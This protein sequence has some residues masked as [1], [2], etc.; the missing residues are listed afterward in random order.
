MP[1]EAVP[2]LRIRAANDLA[3]RADGSFVLYW[4]IAARRRLA[5]FGLQR[6]V[7]L[8]R[9]L[10]KP[11]LVLEALR[12]DYRWASD[13]LHAFV[14]QGMADNLVEFGD[15]GVTYHA[16]VEPEPGAGDG[17]LEA[18]GAEACAVVTDD[19][20]CFFLPRMVAA[21]AARVPV[22]MEAVDSNGLLPMRAADKVFSRAFD[23]RRF[24][25]KALAPH[26]SHFPEGDPLR[27]YDLGAA[28]LPAGLA[29][30]W[31]AA[32]EGLLT[33]DVE[34]LAALPI[35]HEVG[36]GVLHGGP[37]AAGKAL[38][39]F[40]AERIDRYGAERSH[41][42]SDS[43]SGLSPYLHF[44]HI[45]AHQVFAGLAQREEWTRERIVDTKKGQRGWYGMGEAAE[46]FLDELVTWR[47]LGLNFT[48]QRDDYDQYESLPEWARKSLEKHAPDAR[49][50]VY[51]LDEFAE[52]ETHDRVWNAA[53]RQLRETGVMQNYLRML[54]GKKVLEWSR[55]PQEAMA[56][57]IELN[58]RYA[59]DG[60]N[61][62]SYS[63]ISWVL[64]RYDR[65][66][67]PER[68]VYGVIRYMSSDNTVRKLKM[69][70]Y[71]AEWAAGESGL[72]PQP[73]KR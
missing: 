73:R 61:P 56:I 17:L 37:R 35:D 63:G 18:L 66:W 54:W 49:S 67:A 41:P 6:A 32:D 40:L 21:A 59:L 58:N 36:P 5:N 62:N 55:T 4:M 42:D 60:R 64:G 9:E 65:P 48:S 13:R 31:P 68:D 8:G 34:E 3:T 47:E 70:G 45:S 23:F 43:P 38:R 71:L 25:Q 39:A 33:G 2:D 30:R 72:L 26:L 69:K 57:L 53:Q 20:P 11:V 28:A 1:T 44:G 52:G 12:C 51:S 16:Y 19:F 50:H 14:L 24:L 46:A 22:R 10:G 29:K 15:A 27:G 7:E